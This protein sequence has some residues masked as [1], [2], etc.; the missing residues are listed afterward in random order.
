[1]C[2]CL[3]SIS[4]Q[5]RDH[6]IYHREISYAKGCILEIDKK[7]NFETVQ[8]YYL[9]LNE[10]NELHTWSLVKDNILVVIEGTMPEKEIQEYRAVLADMEQLRTKNQKLKI[11]N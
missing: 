5:Q 9:N 4:Y 2:C 7:R 10:N 3:F 1:M 11:Q 6:T 8:N